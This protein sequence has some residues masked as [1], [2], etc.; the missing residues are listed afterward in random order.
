MKYAMSSAFELGGCQSGAVTLVKNQCPPVS[1]IGT[2]VI[3]KR[4]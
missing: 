3:E 1:R 4:W 2:S